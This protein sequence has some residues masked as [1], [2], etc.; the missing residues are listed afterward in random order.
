MWKFFKEPKTTFQK[1]DGHE[2]HKR[3]AIKIRYKKGIYTVAEFADIAGVPYMTLY[4]RLRKA[5]SVKDLRG[6]SLIAERKRGRP[7]EA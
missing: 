4:M 2:R 3:G 6:E 7:V 1:I 5:K